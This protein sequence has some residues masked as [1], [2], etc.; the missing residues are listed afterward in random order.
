MIGKQVEVPVSLKSL[1]S[2]IQKIQ[3][4]NKNKKTQK[5][6]RAYHKLGSRLLIGVD[7][8]PTGITEATLVFLDLKQT[9]PK[10]C[11]AN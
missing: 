6:M 10:S 3:G 4:R 1:Q 11:L 8:L 2:S 9:G 7:F 5:K